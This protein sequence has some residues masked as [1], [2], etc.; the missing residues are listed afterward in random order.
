D[1]RRRPAPGAT[2]RAPRGR[3]AGV[4]MAQSQRFAPL[5]RWWMDQ[6]MKA[7]ESRRQCLLPVPGLIH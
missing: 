7:L 6:N 2:G 4:L 3:L 5:A 1:R